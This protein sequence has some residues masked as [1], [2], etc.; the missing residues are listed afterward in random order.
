[1]HART[2][3]QTKLAVAKTNIFISTQKRH[4]Q[5]LPKLFIYSI[6]KEIAEEEMQVMLLT[7][8]EGQGQREAFFLQPPIA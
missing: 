6:K 5:T 4:Q 2:H 3:K 7:L 1:M 8:V